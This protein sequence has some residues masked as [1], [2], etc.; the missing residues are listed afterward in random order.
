[1][2]FL[3]FSMF[4]SVSANLGCIRLHSKSRQWIILT[5]IGVIECTSNFNVHTLIPSNAFTSSPFV[6]NFHLQ[7]S[8]PSE[9]RG[10]SCPSFCSIS[11]SCSLTSLS[12]SIVASLAF[13]Q[14]SHLLFLGWCGFVL[15]ETT[16]E[17]KIDWGRWLYRLPRLCR[18]YGSKRYPTRH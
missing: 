18:S 10:R 15:I 8:G 14:V 11:I 1:M 17:N 2:T 9:V 3:W 7:C 12:L 5:Q 16:A 13:C 6:G 4:C